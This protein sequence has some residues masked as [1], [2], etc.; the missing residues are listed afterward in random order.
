MPYLIALLLVILDQLTKYV[1]YNKGLFSFAYLF[2][3]HVFNQWISWWIKIFPFDVLK[4]ITIII[5]WIIIRAY[6]K[7]YI[8]PIAFTLL[9]AGGI[10]NLIDR[11]FLGWVR[12]FITIS[13]YFPT[14]NL[15]DI[16]ITLGFLMVLIED[17]IWYPDN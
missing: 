13:P 5:L 1:F 2:S 8:W 3:K 9:L 6:K 12:D 10:W 14:F 7:K 15:A 16:F 11:F 17:K 4:L